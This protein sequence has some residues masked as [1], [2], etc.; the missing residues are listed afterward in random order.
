MKRDQPSPT[1]ANALTTDLVFDH[2]PL[3][4]K[5]I[6]EATPGQILSQLDEID[7]IG[8]RRAA[9]LAGPAR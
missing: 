7:A 8:V 9:A 5:M 6:G 3:L 4:Q 2:T 1:A